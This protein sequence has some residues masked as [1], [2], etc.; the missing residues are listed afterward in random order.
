MPAIGY[1][2]L[3]NFPEVRGGNAI[4]EG[5]R[6]GCMTWSVADFSSVSVTNYAGDDVGS[7]TDAFRL[8]QVVGV[9]SAVGLIGRSAS[10]GRI[11]PRS[12]IGGHSGP[13]A[14]QKS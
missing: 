4:V 5:T 13:F 8:A 10:P 7:I 9:S 12:I 3:V 1:R 11:E 14:V 6:I 2:Y